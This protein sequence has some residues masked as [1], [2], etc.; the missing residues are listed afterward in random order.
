MVIYW[1][2]L[3]IIYQFKRSVFCL[4]SIELDSP[5]LSFVEINAVWFACTTYYLLQISPKPQN[6]HSEINNNDTNNTF[7]PWFSP[8]KTKGLVMVKWEHQV[9]PPPSTSTLILP[10]PGAGWCS[11][12]KTSNSDTDA[13]SCGARGHRR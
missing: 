4:C 11:K 5:N 9:H 1:I 7:S 3:T 2:L 10:P 8:G 13:W 6:S 12:L